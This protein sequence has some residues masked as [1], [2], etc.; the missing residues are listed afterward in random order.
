M[1]E[2]HGIVYNS[3]TFLFEVHIRLHHE[4]AT[5]NTWK[6]RELVITHKVECFQDVHMKYRNT[7][8]CI[9]IY[10]KPIHFHAVYAYLELCVK[11]FSFSSEF[12]D[13]SLALVQFPTQLLCQ[14]IE[15][16]PLP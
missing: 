9:C 15:L 16:V 6:V 13:L 8:V 4:H 14:G 10:P 3:T 2:Q 11:V 12:S 5:S 7:V 1:F